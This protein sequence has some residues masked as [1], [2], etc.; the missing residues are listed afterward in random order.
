[1][2]D[3]Q[4]AIRY[5]AE[6]FPPYPEKRADFQ[7]TPGE[8]WYAD[9]HYDFIEKLKDAGLSEP[10]QKEAV[11]MLD[12]LLAAARKYGAKSKEFTTRQYKVAE[13]WGAKHPVAMTFISNVVGIVI[14]RAIA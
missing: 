8:Q 14:G 13:E 9:Q 12:S 11:A 6:L 3:Q 4:E 10:E 5:A 7:G 2:A 1:M